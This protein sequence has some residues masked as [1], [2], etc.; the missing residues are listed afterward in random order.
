MAVL[1]ATVKLIHMMHPIQD[2]PAMAQRIGYYMKNGRNV[3]YE[4]QFPDGHTCYLTYA[5]IGEL[6]EA[7]REYETA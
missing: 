4:L 1:N 2:V 5:E 7:E 3:G 6:M